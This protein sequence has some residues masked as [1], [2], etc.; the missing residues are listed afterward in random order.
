MSNTILDERPASLEC[1]GR[2][3]SALIN[4]LRGRRAIVCGMSA[5]C[6]GIYRLSISWPRPEQQPLIETETENAA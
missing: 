6:P 5:A 1:H 3:L 2:E 4:E